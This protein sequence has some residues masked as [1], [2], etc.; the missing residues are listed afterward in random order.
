M[1]SISKSEP[2]A[3][4]TAVFPYFDNIQFWRREPLDREIRRWLHSE[5]RRFYR[6]ADKPARFDCRLRERI[7]LKG[8]SPDGLLWLA[9]EQDAFINRTEIAIDIHFNDARARDD[10]FE[11]LI[12]HLVRRHHRRNQEIRY[13]REED[14]KPWREHRICRAETRYDG[15]RWAP[16]LTIIYKQESC[17]ITGEVAPLLH[18]EW[19]ANGIKAVRSLGI[20]SAADLSNFNHTSFWVH[21]LLLLDIS[22]ERLGRLIR[23]QRDGTKSRASTPADRRVGNLLLKRYETIQQLLDQ[24]GS[25]IRRISE[26]IPNDLWLPEPCSAFSC[27][28]PRQSNHSPSPN[29]TRRAITY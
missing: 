11:F 15:P 27:Y 23:N 14:G 12:R 26:R 8:L 16:H 28:T 24:Y 29:L 4:P 6:D 2:P 21:R 9:S 17:R 3:E 7:Q 5:C 20:H 13:Y 19:R 1:R 22:P 25:P 10:T 18:V